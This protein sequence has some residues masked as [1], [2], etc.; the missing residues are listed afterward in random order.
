MRLHENDRQGIE[1]L[2]RYGARGPLTLGRL[3]RDADDR[4]RYG[5]KRT[6]RGRDELVMTGKELTKKL[7][8]LVPPPRV[9]LVRFHGL[10]APNAKLRAKVVPAGKKVPKRCAASATTTTTPSPEATRDRP[11]PRDGSSRID[12]A[13]LLRR[14]FKIDVLA[15]GRCGGR[16]K[17]IAVIEEQP[18]IE[19]ILGHLRLPH[20][21]LPTAPARGQR[22]FDFF[23]A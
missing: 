7:A 12:W 8:V 6:V 10:F 1:R 21:P 23:A 17:V 14:I 19:K 4:Y 2:C 3:T 9:H 16:M 5:M 11:S 22:A 13:A 20:V 15:C 18:V